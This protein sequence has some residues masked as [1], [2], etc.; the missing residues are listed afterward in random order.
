MFEA[1]SHWRS[2]TFKN[3]SRGTGRQEKIFR[4]GTPGQSAE[5]G[6]A[7]DD[8]ARYSDQARCSLD[9]RLNWGGR[10]SALDRRDIE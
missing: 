1:F 10:P 2:T 7:M 9:P 8:D 3:E 6:E 5:G 4:P